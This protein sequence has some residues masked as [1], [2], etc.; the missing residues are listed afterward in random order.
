MIVQKTSLFP[1][2]KETVFRK[3]Q[4][5]ETL[6]TISRPYAKFE[7]I[8]EAASTWAV[9]CTSA[10]RFQLFGVIPYTGRRSR[11]RSY[12]TCT[13]GS[14]AIWR[15][16]CRSP[17]RIM[18]RRIPRTR[19]ETLRSCEKLQSKFGTTLMKLQP[20]K[21]DCPREKCRCFACCRFAN[22]MDSR[23]CLSKF[24]WGPVYVPAFDESAG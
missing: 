9:G 15:W 1:A 3:L 13:P 16:S 21:S 20:E 6:Q 22:R 8:G 7:P 10:Y 24:L 11:I 5:L 19:G 14:S 2:S 18:K 4:Q 12:R 23:L 17:T